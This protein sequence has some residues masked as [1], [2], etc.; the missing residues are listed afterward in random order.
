MGRL[1]KQDAQNRLAEIGPDALKLARDTRRDIALC[2]RIG[3]KENATLIPRLR[4]EVLGYIRQCK[5]EYRALQ[6]A[7]EDGLFD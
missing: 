3:A 2:L 4:R 7:L 1:S 5:K 6:A